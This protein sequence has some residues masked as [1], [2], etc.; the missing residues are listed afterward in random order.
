MDDVDPGGVA[1]MAGI[2]KG[3]FLLEVYIITWFDVGFCIYLE[4]FLILNISLL[5]WGYVTEQ[6][7]QGNLDADLPSKKYKWL[8]PKWQIRIRINQHISVDIPFMI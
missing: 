3:D 2:Q 7:L 4:G 8:D 6:F 1:D 5:H